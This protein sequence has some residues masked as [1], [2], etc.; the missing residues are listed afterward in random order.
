MPTGDLTQEQERLLVGRLIAGQDGAW[1]V[2]LQ[3]FQ[4]G[5]SFCVRRAGISDDDHEDACAFVLESLFADGCRRLQ[6]WEGRNGARLSTYL[7]AVSL[8]LARD[9]LRNLPRDVRFRAPEARIPE[10]GRDIGIALGPEARA[11][12]SRLRDAILEC[13]FSMPMGPD[14]EILLFHFYAGLGAEDIAR[15][16]GKKR[17]AVDQALLRARRNLRD[18]AENVHPELVEYLEDEGRGA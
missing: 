7:H 18:V 14:R 5:I 17:N 16:S 2:F 13:L 11:L 9:Y 6:L 8:N 10:T 12:Q 4:G 15:L 1:E 3:H